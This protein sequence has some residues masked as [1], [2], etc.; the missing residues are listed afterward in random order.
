MLNFL[1][2]V[3]GW[4]EGHEHTVDLMKWGTACIVAWLL[5][6]FR[7][8]RVWARRPSISVDSIYSRFYLERHA[9]LGNNVDVTLLAF[10]VDAQVMNPTNFRIGIRRFELQIG[11]SGL[12]RTWAKPVSAVGFP[13]MPRTPMPGDNIKV[14]PIWMTAFAE[15]DASLTLKE[16]AERDSATGLVFFVVT[17]PTAMLPAAMTECQVK[18]RA[19]VGTGEKCSV[20]AVI[21]LHADFGH[22]DRTIPGSIPF[23][24]HESVWTH[25]T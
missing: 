23:V 10:V 21:D 20:K 14:V 2:P 17:V 3:I 7:A 9:A 19:V 1:V 16:V 4:I 8:V 25:R 22:L 18:V 5:G 12:M 15:F 13:A 6:V 24:R 11:R